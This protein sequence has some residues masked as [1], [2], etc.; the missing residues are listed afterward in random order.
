MV[1]KLMRKVKNQ[2]VVAGI[3]ILTVAG[4]GA[5]MNV[6]AETSD[7]DDG[8][9][10]TNSIAEQY[11]A[12]EWIARTVDETK[13]EIKDQGDDLQ[14]GY[15]IKWG[16][17]LW[18]I[19]QATGIPISEIVAANNLADP[20]L[21]YAG[22][23]LYV[24]PTQPTAN[25]Q[26]TSRVDDT[27]DD[28]PKKVTQ[29]YKTPAVNAPVANY[30]NTKLPQQS[31]TPTTVPQQNNTQTEN[32][33]VDA[34]TP[35]IPKPENPAIPTPENPV[36]PTPENPTIPT[37]EIPTTPILTTRTIEET[38]KTPFDIIYVEDETLNLGEE[39]IVQD[40]I[41]GITINTYTEVLRNQLLE[42]K[43]LTG[44]VV[45]SEP[46]NQI[47]HEGV[48]EVKQESRVVSI[49]FGTSYQYDDTLEA[50]KTEILQEGSMGEAV[51]TY[52]VIYVKGVKIAEESVGTTVTKIPVNQIVNTGTQLVETKSEMVTENSVPYA[53]VEQEDGS[54]LNGEKKVIQAGSNGYDKVTYEVTYRNG[55]ES[56][57]VEVGRETVAP[58]NEIVAVGT[59]LPVSSISL[60]KTTALLEIGE[61]TFLSL[62]ILPNGA[63]N[64]AASWA[65][66]D[67]SVATVDVA[68]NV[69]GVGKGT[70]TITAT[71]GD[72]TAT[73]EVT[74]AKKV[75]IP[76]IS[77]S[78]DKATLNLTEGGSDTLA[79]SLNPV[80]TTDDKKVIWT[81]SDKKIATVDDYGNVT[82]VSA[83]TATIM[84]RV[85]GNTATSQIF[86]TE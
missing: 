7:V 23:W 65:S 58:T 76:L 22:D 39:R 15:L 31:N 64:Q 73:C 75:K 9:I 25:T 79:V 30:Q 46:K 78:L 84:A 53:T 14:A 57:R 85:G 35:I 18:A 1:K 56:N 77:I 61:T 3:S 54:L 2:W 86:V 52:N 50:G 81:S 16:D 41:V 19:S 66:S 36:I 28:S 13:K 82:A 34:N 63:T 12:V 47:V 5:S 74:V 62:T 49:Q 10:E 32:T 38:V 70:A 21:I 59:F 72:K 8:K 80:D 55:S 26:Q 71:V 24:S 6:S 69:T 51:E 20:D 44:T 29:S 68:G 67:N 60:G 48:K 11:R 27:G 40:G 37:P 83:G 43:T 17:T 33:N 45:V 42:S 4:V